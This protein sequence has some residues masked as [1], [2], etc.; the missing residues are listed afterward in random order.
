MVIQVNYM[1]RIYDTEYAIICLDGG[2]TTTDMTSFGRVSKT[3]D[4][5]THDRHPSSY[6]Y[7]GQTIL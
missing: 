7:I 3:F 2:C 4:A 5:K 1:G 6:A